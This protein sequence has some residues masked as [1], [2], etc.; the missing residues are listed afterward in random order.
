[1]ECNYHLTN[2]YALF[3]NMSKYYKSIGRDP[4][5]VLPLSFHIKNGSHDPTFFKFMQVF[6]EYEERV[7][8]SESS[9]TSH[10]KAYKS[11][12]ATPKAPNDDGLIIGENTIAQLVSES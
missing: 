1:M 8:K 5:D 4:L 12:K 9:C 3:V 2:K 6:R 11:S 7:K 10:K